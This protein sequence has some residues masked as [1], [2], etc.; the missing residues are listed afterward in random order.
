MATKT[1]TSINGREYYRI[2]R[3]IDGKQ[4]SFYGKS[5]LDAERKYKEHLEELARLKYQKNIELSEATFG[6]HA[7]E[8]VNNVL[9]VSQKYAKGTRELYIRIYKNHV[10]DASICKFRMQDLRASH[11]QAFYNSL[12]VSKQTMQSVHKFMSAFFKWIVAN[13]YGANVLSAVEIPVKENTKKNDDIVTW[14]DDEVRHILKS[15]TACSVPF[16][17]TFFIKTLLYTGMRISEAM[18]LKYSDIENDVINVERQYVFGEIKPPKYNSC[19]QIP[20]HPE[21]IKAFEEHRAWHEAEMIKNGYDTDYIF[22]TSTGKLYDHSNLRTAL[23]RF[24][25]KHKIP[26]KHPHAYRATFCTNLCRN[27]APLEVT[28]KLMGHKSLE[29]TAAHYAQVRQDSK[30]DAINLLKF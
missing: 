13:D 23:K 14:S 5:K 8:Y 21:L 29:V 4:K 1:N 20:M 10:K 15:L 22:T 11:I 24:Y 18:A 26:Y 12:D 25:N 3:M 19:R 30:V 17:Q 27:G 6:E 2:R 28:S 7:E 9:S 16:R